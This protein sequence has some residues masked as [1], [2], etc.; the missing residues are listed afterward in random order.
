MQRRPLGVD[1]PS[2]STAE[3]V[4]LNTELNKQEGNP[5]KSPKPEK[6]RHSSI[7]ARSFFLFFAVLIILGLGN[8]YHQSHPLVSTNLP[9]SFPDNALADDNRTC[10]GAERG[11]IP[12]ELTSLRRTARRWDPFE[13]TVAASCSRLMPLRA[14]PPATCASSPSAPLLRVERA[15]RL[16]P[17]AHEVGRVLAA[18]LPAP[19]Q[20]QAALRQP[21]Q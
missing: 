14:V 3:A 10:P 15:L 13:Y 20:N 6:K 17:A 18:L 4:A 8:F 5:P 7:R 11:I 1:I 12:G 9:E 21:A 16:L 2:G 19:S